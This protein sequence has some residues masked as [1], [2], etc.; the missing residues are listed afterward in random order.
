M[1]VPSYT[2]D[3]LLLIN[4]YLYC[5]YFISYYQCN[6]FNVCDLKPLLTGSCSSLLLILQFRCLSKVCE[7]FATVINFTLT[8]FG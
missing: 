6:C 3:L 5:H 8:I 4:I 1:S 7:V 2:L